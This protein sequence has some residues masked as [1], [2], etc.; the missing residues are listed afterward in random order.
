MEFG[1]QTRII[2]SPYG[3]KAQSLSFDRETLENLDKNGFLVPFDCNEIAIPIQF[4]LQSTAISRS[5]YE[6]RNSR[7]SVP[8]LNIDIDLVITEMHISNREK[9]RKTLKKIK[10]NGLNYFESKVCQLWSILHSQQ[11]SIFLMTST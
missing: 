8:L 9:R 7:I 10:K 3:A 6:V 2:A 1:R 11:Q 5:R 4:S